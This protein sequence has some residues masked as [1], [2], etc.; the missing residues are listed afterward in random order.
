MC[1]VHGR[2]GWI[3][4]AYPTG[5]HLSWAGTGTKTGSDN[6]PC[7]Y[8]GPST[9]L[10]DADAQTE[11]ARLAEERDKYKKELDLVTRL[12]CSL[13]KNVQDRNDFDIDA[14]EDGELAK[15]WK[16]HVKMDAKRLM[17]EAKESE[18]AKLEKQIA[19]I[20][21]ELK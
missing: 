2:F 12:L 20:K 9:G 11:R 3:S 8:Y 6:M 14:I 18:I 10:Y 1:V 13:I 19:E 15:W 17:R 7:T 16:K 4:L 5:I 21:K